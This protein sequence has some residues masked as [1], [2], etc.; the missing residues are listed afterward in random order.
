MIVMRP[1]TDQQG[2]LDDLH[3]SGALHSADQYVD[4]HQHADHRDHHRLADA[5]LDV[6]QQG[7][8]P[9]GTGHLGE[10]IKQAYRERGG[11]RGDPYRSLAQAE[12]QHVGH[13]EFACIAQQFGNEEQRHQPGHQ[14]TDRIE[15]AVVAVDRDRACDAEEAGRREIVAGDRDAVL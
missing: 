9:A 12:A 7:H 4:D 3:P 13:R 15:E 2:G 8:Q 14:E 10:Q 11:G 5:A 1:A 6:E